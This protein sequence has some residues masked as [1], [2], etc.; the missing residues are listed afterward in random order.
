MRSFDARTAARGPRGT[1]C[2]IALA[3]LALACAHSPS[4]TDGAAPTPRPGEQNATMGSAEIAR[5][6]N[7]SVDKYLNGRFPGVTVAPSPD[8]GVTIRIRGGTS[9]LG[10]NE[11]L[12]VLDGVVLQP[13]VSGSLAINPYDI[14]SIKVLKESTDITMYGVRGANGVIVIKTKR[15]Q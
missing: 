7:E 1:L 2:L 13:S 15:A 3:S 9:A 10:N 4:K 8:G 14:A 6:P 12:Y 5:Q 11:P